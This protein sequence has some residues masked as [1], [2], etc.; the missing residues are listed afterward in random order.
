MRVDRTTHVRE[1]ASRDGDQRHREIPSVPRPL[2]HVPLQ[3]RP[4]LALLHQAIM[5]TAGVLLRNTD[6]AATLDRGGDVDVLVSD[7]AEAKEALFHVLGPPRVVY[8]RSYVWSLHYDWGHI[9]LFPALDWRGAAYLDK[10]TVLGR[11][12]RQPSL[13]CRVSDLD[14]AV[15]CWL[16]SVLWGGFFK[17]RYRPLIERLARE[18]RAALAEVLQVAFGPRWGRLLASAAASG[19][20]ELAAEQ[21]VR[22]RRAVRRRALRR[23]PLTTIRGWV[24]FWWRE[25][26]LRLRPPLPWL[27]VLGPD[28]SGKTS[29]IDALAV[30]WPADLGRVVRHHWRPH[31]LD[32]RR[33]VEGPVVDPHGLPPR[34]VAASVVKLGW[35][36]ADWWIGTAAVIANQRARKG[37]VV[38]DRHYLDLLVD[39]RRY[40][41]GAPAWLAAALARVIP[42]PDLLIVLDA[43]VEVLHSRKKEV[44]AGE[45]ERQRTRYRALAHSR[46]GGVVLDASRSTED[47]AA[48]IVQLLLHDVARRSRR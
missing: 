36:A 13:P 47:V 45:A 9:D 28:G 48:Q 31:H 27:A 4:D 24:H 12:V 33:R 39:P 15:C 41:Y 44:P 5:A 3:P 19:R 30:Q 34:G 2:D 20:P 6:V 37:L 43:P 16:T 7:L 17:E 8:R 14:E 21:A 35:I 10:H 42:A 26:S 11:A 18:D 29:V 22:L 40:R 32:Q 1:A 38:F 46:P 25:A 23:E